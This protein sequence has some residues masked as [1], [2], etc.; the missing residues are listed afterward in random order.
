MHLLISNENGETG[1]EFD[2]DLTRFTCRYKTMYHCSQCTWPPLVKLKPNRA[3]ERYIALEQM[4]GD[5]LFICGNAQRLILC[6]FVLQRSSL[7]CLLVIILELAE[8]P[9]LLD[10]LDVM[11]LAVELPLVRDV[12][13][14]ADGASS[15]AALEAALVIHSVVDSY[16]KNW[17]ECCYHAN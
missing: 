15:M 14:R 11:M 6:F 5:S 9:L 16:L 2:S 4:Q 12:V 3:I 7:W 8:V 17:C 1:R 13:R 10:Q